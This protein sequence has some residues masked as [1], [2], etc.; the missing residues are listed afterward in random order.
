ME[1][2]IKEG[3]VVKIKSGEI[4]MTVGNVSNRDLIYCYYEK[5]GIIRGQE[6]PPCILMVV[7]DK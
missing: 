4:K 5:D 7:E 1:K 6:F 2:E 3:D